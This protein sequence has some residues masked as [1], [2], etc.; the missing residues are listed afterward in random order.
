M[1]LDITVCKGATKAPTAVQARIK[2]SSEPRDEA[3][4]LGLEIP[5]INDD[6]PARAAGV[7]PDVAYEVN[8]Q[9]GFRA[10][11]YGGYNEWRKQLA[12][13]TGIT[14][15]R[16][17]VRRCAE[18]EDDG[19]R[20]DH[21]FAELIWFSDCEGVIGPEVAARLAK[22]FKEWDE[23][24]RDCGCDDHEWWYE[25]Y[26]TWRRAFEDAAQGGFVVFH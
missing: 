24:A 25:L 7:E 3:Y 9:W 2:L 18:I 4:D 23:R 5:W 8:E 17:F 19:G 1:G 20:L 21:P 22:D 10:G 12:E 6:F 11:S 13:L 26:G 15:Q 16:A 14:D